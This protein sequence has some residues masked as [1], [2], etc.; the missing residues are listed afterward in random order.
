MNTP[1]IKRSAWP[2]TGGAFLLALL[3]QLLLLGGLVVR[4]ERAISGGRTVF[5][6]VQH[7]NVDR[8]KRDGSF[9]PN[10]ALRN[11]SLA[12]LTH[13]AAEFSSERTAFRKLMWL[14]LEPGLPCWQP[15]E[16]RS[17]APPADGGGLWLRVRITLGLGVV[18]VR[19]AGSVAT[20]MHE[21]VDIE[22]ALRLFYRPSSL[23]G[24]N[25]ADEVFP[26][27]G[28]ALSVRISVSADG[29][30]TVEDL[31]VGEVSWDEWIR[32]E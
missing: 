10:L 6:E 22:P 4:E 11:H 24:R 8:S 1:L 32:G 29:R 2:S 12:G 25:L 17:S 16:L 14:R 19:G 28:P 3:F 27:D 31:L 13:D 30:G 20:G 5:L 26:Q 21:L 9:R 7:T 18:D 23:P 15:V